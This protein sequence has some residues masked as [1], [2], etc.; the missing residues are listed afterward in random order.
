[1]TFGPIQLIPPGLLGLFQLKQMGKNPSQYGE[2]VLPSFE[3]SDWY[4][5]AASLDYNAQVGVALI[6]GVDLANG[7]VGF[8][9]FSPNAV[10]VPAN[11]WW[12][13]E[14]YTVATGN[15]TTGDNTALRPAFARPLTGTRSIHVVNPANTG[16]LGGAATARANTVSGVD[17]WVPPGS[18]IGMFVQVN[19]TATVISYTGYLR[20]TPCRI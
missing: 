2:V 4:L 15:L 16:V 5:R 11:E 19:D 12:H 6:P 1:M 9:G 18:E 20:Y 10:I 3:L 7:A 8:Q 14:N 17:F 13:V